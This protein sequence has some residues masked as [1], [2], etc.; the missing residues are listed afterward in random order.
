MRPRAATVPA[1]PRA[2]A[3]EDQLLL[4]L[5]RSHCTPGGEARARD[6]LTQ[7][8]SWPR[9]VRRARDHDLLPFLSRRL[10]H[11]DLFGV[12]AEVRQ[13]C[14]AAYRVTA[15]LN[16]LYARELVR[17]LE[18][19]GAAKV[20]TI[21]LKGVALATSLYGD[22]ALR[23]SSDLDI[24]VPAAA[25]AQALDALAQT[26][27]VAEVTDSFFLRVLL[28]HDI[29]LALLRRTDALDYP[30][31]VHWSIGWPGPWERAGMTALW[32]AAHRATFQ[33]AP[34]W[35]LPPEWELL[36]L[37]VHA[38]RHRWGRLKWLV[39]L[40]TLCARGGIDWDRVTSTARRFGWDRALRL[41]LGICRALL[42][43]PLPD[44]VFRQPLPPWVCPFPADLPREGVAGVRVPLNLLD[45]PSEK[46]R[47]LARVLLV[48]T[49]AE[50]R[51][52]CLPASA[53]LLY[54]PLRPA[55]LASKWGIRLMRSGPGVCR[56]GRLGGRSGL[57]T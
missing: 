5:V 12:P 54:Y 56:S 37:A 9:F 6:L 21:P 11:L 27:Y 25:A 36:V 34:A 26:G 3:P 33:G 32:A 40:D 24:L 55:R 14:V 46:L 2:M 29:E 53:R 51:L 23:V 10:D 18:L 1:G 20:P 7:P 38:A 42:E 15:V 30:L 39:D 8:L 49:L 43:T 22:P 28:R 41:S 50:R 52:V 45:R 44:G 48:P 57:R 31:D 47:H 17:V 35:T 19:L 13:A 16:D 4:Q